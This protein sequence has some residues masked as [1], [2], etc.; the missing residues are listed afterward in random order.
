MKKLIL[1]YREKGDYFLLERTENSE[2]VIGEIDPKN[3]FPYN[4]PLSK[5]NCDEL[6][7]LVDV[8]DFA[9]EVSQLDDY[10][11]GR[12]YGRVEGFKKA[13]ELNKDKLFTLYEIKEAI[14]IA[15]HIQIDE[16]GV[17]TEYKEEQILRMVQQP[18]EIEVEFATI[19]EPA[20]ENVWVSPKLDE[21]GCIT[22]KKK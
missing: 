4:L 14:R 8:I 9:S 6:F 19:N 2:S 11:K 5:K 3:E 18:T 20:G 7:N 17:L 21:N 1:K 22:L 13:Q 16:K 10:D 12:W 15:Q